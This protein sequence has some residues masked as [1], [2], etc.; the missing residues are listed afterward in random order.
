MQQFFQKL[1]D[2]LES[3]VAPI[4]N[5]LDEEVALYHE[6]YPRFVALGSL[7][8]LTPKELGGLGGERKEWIEY[9]ILMAQ[10]SGALLFLQA[11]HQFC[12]SRLKQLLPNQKVAEVLS[13]LVREER[14]IGL[15]LAKTSGLLMVE[16]VEEG[17]RLSGK[18]L[19]M[20]KP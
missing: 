10:Y 2:F 13:T 20:Y 19:S 11:Q 16:A 7:N 1:T 12:V 6:I 9:N 3:E 8:L 14:G 4:A 5:R 17:Y 15:A 18:L